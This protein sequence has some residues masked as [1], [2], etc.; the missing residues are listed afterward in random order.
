MVLIGCYFLVETIFFREGVFD[1]LLYFVFGVAALTFGIA[2]LLPRSQTRLAGLMRISGSGLIVL[3]GRTGHTIGRLTRL[4][5]TS[6][7]WVVTLLEATRLVPGRRLR[8]QP[9]ARQ[10]LLRLE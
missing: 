5:Q 9:A 1:R 8:A 6:D 3:R 7:S 10:A 2:D 4:S